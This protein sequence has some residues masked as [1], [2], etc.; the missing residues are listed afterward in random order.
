[1]TCC[2]SLVE[3]NTGPSNSCKWDW[4]QQ[5]P[6]TQDAVQPSRPVEFPHIIIQLLPPLGS[7]G[8]SYTWWQQWLHIPPERLSGIRL[9]G[10]E[11]VWPREGF[12]DSA[13][14]F[15]MVKMKY[16]IL[17]DGGPNGQSVFPGSWNYRGQVGV[18][19]GLPTEV[20]VEVFCLQPIT[21]IRSH[22]SSSQ[23]SK[24]SCCS[25]PLHTPGPPALM[26]AHL[27]FPVAC[28]HVKLINQ[29]PVS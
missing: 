14:A 11:Y 27:L 15:G 16:C 25:K 8:P 17:G 13:S 2:L 4:G 9:S 24:G 29:L 7:T 5:C 28:I 23:P 22:C 6:F 3:S 20:F 21:P 26:T 1:V 19:V 12:Q 10:S 18:Q